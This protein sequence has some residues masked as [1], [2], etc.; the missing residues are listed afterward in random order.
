[1][2]EAPTTAIEEGFKSLEM[3]IKN[4]FQL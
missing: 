3:D 4:N 2:E 1:L